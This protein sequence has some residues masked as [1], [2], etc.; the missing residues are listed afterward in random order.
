MNPEIRDPRP[1]VDRVLV[2]AQLLDEGHYSA[3]H[4][5][6]DTMVGALPYDLHG[7]AERIR[8]YEQLLDDARLCHD[9]PRAYIDRNEDEGSVRGSLLDYSEWKCAELDSEAADV[10]ADIHTR[11]EVIAAK[12]DAVGVAA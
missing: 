1:N 12:A 2:A 4:L 11:A 10:L 9:D 7:L 5:I 8:E 6:V 3:A